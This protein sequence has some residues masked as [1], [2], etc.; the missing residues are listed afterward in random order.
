MSKLIKPI[1]KL[2]ELLP[3]KEYSFGITLYSSPIKHKFVFI[4]VDNQIS[5]LPFYGADEYTSIMDA[6]SNYNRSDRTE[7]YVIIEDYCGTH[8]RILKSNISYI[9]NCYSSKDLNFDIKS[10]MDPEAILCKLRNEFS[11][12]GWDALT[13]QDHLKIIDYCK[14]DQSE[15]M[16]TVGKIYR[17]Q[18]NREVKILGRT[19]IKG[20]EC[21]I[22]SDGKYRYDRSTNNLDS[23]RGTGTNGE[24]LHPHNLIREDYGNRYELLKQFAEK[25]NLDVIKDENRLMKIGHQYPLNDLSV[26]FVNFLNENDIKPIGN[27]CTRKQNSEKII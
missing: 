17:T 4:G 9:H 5:Q 20:Y 26:L 24:Y 23:G 2:P 8:F 6:I 3:N 10:K 14:I 12:R 19:Y 16:F 21:L 27:L 18:L 22:C 13:L 25:Y 7:E 15:Y 11:H 1:L